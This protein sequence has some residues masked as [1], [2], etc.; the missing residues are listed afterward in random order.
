MKKT[1]IIILIVLPMFIQAQ[2]IL[3]EYVS[4]GLDNNLALKQKYSG[5]Q[6]SLEALREAR[7]L[8]FPKYFPGRKVYCLRGRS[9]Y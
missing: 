8:F 4:Y 5:Y 3:D 1:M 2:D 7:G 9:C 6:R